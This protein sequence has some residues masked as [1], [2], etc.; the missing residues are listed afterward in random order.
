VPEINQLKMI[1]AG[2]QFRRVP[3]Y[4]YHWP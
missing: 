3:P 2:T 1:G 4:F